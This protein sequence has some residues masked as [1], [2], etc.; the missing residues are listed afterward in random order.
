M[1]TIKKFPKQLKYLFCDLIWFPKSQKWNSSGICFVPQLGNCGDGNGVE[2]KWNRNEICLT[3]LENT[4]WKYLAFHQEGNWRKSNSQNSS[5]LCQSTP[6]KVC[7]LF[8]FQSNYVLLL[9]LV[10]EQQETVAK[11]NISFL[12]K[13]ITS[14][15][16]CCH[17]LISFIFFL[18]F[19]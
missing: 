10:K 16:D 14:F 5:C 11:R 1:T 9:S 2:Y 8:S 19:L 15:Y 12:Q 13:N 17:H 7:C 3:Q 4:E 18:R 6:N